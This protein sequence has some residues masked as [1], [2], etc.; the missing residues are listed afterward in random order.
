[1]FTIPVSLAQNRKAAKG[2]AAGQ[3]RAKPQSRKVRAK[4]QAIGHLPRAKAQRRKG[5]AKVLAV[6]QRFWQSGKGSGNI[7]APLHRCTAAPLH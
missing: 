7:F 3:S 4:V 6:G 1:L 2:R 5:R